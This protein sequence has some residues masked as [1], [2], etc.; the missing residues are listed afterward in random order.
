MPRRGSAFVSS[1]S[2]RTLR[3]PSPVTDAGTR[4]ATA[5]SLPPT[6]RDESRFVQSTKQMV[7]SGDYVRIRVQQ[8]ERNKKPIGIHVPDRRNR[9]FPRY[10]PSSTSTSSSRIPSSRDWKV[11]R[12]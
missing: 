5:A 7:E 11:S 9:I 10:R 8:D 4:S 1:T 6:D 2:A 12:R 3:T